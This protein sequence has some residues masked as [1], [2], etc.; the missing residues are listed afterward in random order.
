M[1]KQ[2]RQA[3]KDSAPL[4]EPVWNWNELTTTQD[5]TTGEP[6]IEPVWNWNIRWVNEVVGPMQ[7]AL[8]TFNRA[9]VEL[10]FRP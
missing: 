5:P 8:S 7:V 1:K 4:I 6:L 9:S 10:K 3:K 2:E